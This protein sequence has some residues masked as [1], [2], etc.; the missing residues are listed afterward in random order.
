MEASLYQDF[1]TLPTGQD[2]HAPHQTLL[3]GRIATSFLLPLIL[4]LS[5]LS[6][7]TK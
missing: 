3:I 1:V 7:F 4:Q 2:Y 5:K 6:P